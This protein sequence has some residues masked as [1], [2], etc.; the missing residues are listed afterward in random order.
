MACKM[1]CCNIAGSIVNFGQ[2]FQIASFVAA[3]ALVVGAF[4]A[5]SCALTPGLPA[6]VAG[7]VEE[8]E[9]AAADGSDDN[10]VG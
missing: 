8:A 9:E 2:V 4:V 10:A 1:C 6:G 5:S 3:A 7:A